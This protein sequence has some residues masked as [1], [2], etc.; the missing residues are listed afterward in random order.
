MTTKKP[1]NDS[2]SGNRV[3]KLNVL[4]NSSI[5]IRSELNISRNFGENSNSTRD[6]IDLVFNDDDD[7]DEDDDFRTNG[8]VA[9]SLFLNLGGQKAD[10]LVDQHQQQATPTNVNE[11]NSATRFGGRR[12]F[13]NN[14]FLDILEIM[15]T[16]FLSFLFVLF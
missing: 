2:S 3:M 6:G 15:I 13:N 5:M 9:S 8:V 14:S 10:R 7:D 12:V 1:S 16:L 4:K 11:K